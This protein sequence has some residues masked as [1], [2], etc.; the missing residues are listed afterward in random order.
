MYRDVQVLREAG[1]G[2]DA[3]R[4]RDWPGPSRERP[5]VIDYSSEHI[6]IAPGEALIHWASH[7]I[8]SKH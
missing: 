8:Y 3:E 6:P 7:D 5:G 4:P 2:E 1:E